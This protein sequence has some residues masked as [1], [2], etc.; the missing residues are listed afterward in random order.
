MIP[1]DK[2]A[3]RRAATSFEA[4]RIRP[5]VPSLYRADDVVAKR[6]EVAVADERL[7]ILDQERPVVRFR[8]GRAPHSPTR[9]SGSIRGAAHESCNG[10]DTAQKQTAH[11]SRAKVCG[12][13]MAISL[14]KTSLIKSRTSTAGGPAI[15]SG[16]GMILAGARPD[17]RLARR[18]TVSLTPQAGQF[19]FSVSRIRIRRRETAWFSWNGSIAG[20][21]PAGALQGRGSVCV[22]VAESAGLKVIVVVD[23][24]S[25]LDPD[26][27]GRRLAATSCRGR[28][29]RAVARA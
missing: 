4:D 28:L 11:L 16:I 7:E 6:V 10:T 5:S 17:Q 19:H 8:H 15:P 20:C 13:A 1:S 22:R 24:G 2:T 18:T 29:R 3:A 27:I 21:R 23:P 9:R 26:E 25:R 12:P 14:H